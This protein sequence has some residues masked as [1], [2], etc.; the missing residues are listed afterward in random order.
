MANRYGE[1]ALMAARA[2]GKAGPAARW[3]SAMKNLSHTS[4]VARELRG[5]RSAFL[6]LCEA[7]LVKGIDAGEYTASKD[8]KA[9][10]VQAAALLIE[11]AQKW[12]VS[13]LWSSVAGDSKK[14]HSSQMDVVMALWKNDFIVGKK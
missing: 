8:D 7:G 9:Y 14:A 2:N 4:A 6:G 3:E 12:N 5:P 11:D 1:A 10:A 13:T